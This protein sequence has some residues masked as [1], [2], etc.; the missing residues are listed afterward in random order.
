MDDLEFRRAVFAEPCS[1]DERMLKA[2]A[3]DPAK[4]TFLDEMK[5]FDDN[6][7]AAL[8]VEV[9]ENLAERLILRQTLESHQQV[10]RRGRVHLALA[11]SVAFAIGLTVQMFYTPAG[12]DNIGTYSLAHVNHGIKHLY[13]AKENNSVS[14]VNAKLARFGGKFNASMGN[15]VFSNYCDFEG[16]TSLHLIYDSPQGRV[17]VFVTPADGN[18]E[19]VKDFSDDKFIGKGLSFDKAQVTVVGDKGQPIEGFTKKVEE[20]LSWEI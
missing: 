3:G 19:F 15:A 14:Q 18:F 4:Q 17:S 2:A 20:S 1:K 7:G 8:Q 9:P 13:S 6:L 16:V 11:A 12:G 10:R 5:A